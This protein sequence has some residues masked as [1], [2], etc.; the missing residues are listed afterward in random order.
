M[1]IK[2]LKPIKAL[3]SLLTKSATLQLHIE[4]ETRK[5][6]PDWFR[7]ITLKKQRLV[8][9]DKINKLRRSKNVMLLG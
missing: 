5:K 1:A 6:Y 4:D 9:K 7:I 8:I 2:P 3:K